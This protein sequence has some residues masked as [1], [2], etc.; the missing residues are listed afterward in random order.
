MAF[1][2]LRLHVGSLISEIFV[3]TLSGMARPTK[4]PG[5]VRENVL[6]IRLTE[7]ER[8]AIDETAQARGLDSSTWARM[9]LLALVKKSRTKNGGTS[10]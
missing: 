6:R 1:P 4:P 7:V 3:A 5:E 9:E 10:E 8:K 2:W